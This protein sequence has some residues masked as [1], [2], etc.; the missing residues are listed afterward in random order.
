[1]CKLTKEYTEA[2][3]FTGYKY[4][5][6]TE[7][8]KFIS[9]ATGIEYKPGPV[10]IA[11]GGNSHNPAGSFVD[12]DT[13]LKPKG[14]AYSKDMIGRTG[15]FKEDSAV[16]QIIEDLKW[17]TGRVKIGFKQV[18]LK[19]VIEKELMSGTYHMGMF[20]GI[21]FLVVA[22]KTIVSVEKVRDA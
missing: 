8:G 19:L 5:L 11:K 17:C 13:M 22:G 6:E 20:G 21:E 12:E 3:T 7:D 16:L 15:L 14:K 4:A 1:M 9:P 18:I 10:E 2:K